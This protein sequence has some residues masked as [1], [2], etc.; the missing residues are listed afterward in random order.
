MIVRCSSCATRY[1][2]DLADL[3][4]AG[5][6][7]RCTRCGHV[8]HQT[9][10]ADTPEVSDR[11]A[12]SVRLDRPPAWAGW[13]A[14]GLFVIAALA[15]LAL[16]RNAIVAGWPGTVSI[17]DAVG[18]PIQAPQAQGL[19][20]VDVQSERVKEGDRIILLVRG[21]VENTTEKG[22][23]LPPLRAVLV[24]E[25][26]SALHEWPVAALARVLGDGQSTPFESWLEDPPEGA[27]KVS[28]GF[29]ADGED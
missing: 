28:V 20:I 3:G 11:V 1:L 15:G 16:A 9:P 2:V 25:A 26:G 7:V 6:R 13:A 22:R 21:A 19:R 17:Y 29:V 10:G 18:L 14:A 23:R 27:A 5:R 4:E 24:D 8:W 12:P